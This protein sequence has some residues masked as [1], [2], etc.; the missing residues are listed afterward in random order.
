MI[1]KQVLPVIVLLLAVVTLL[2]A[3]GADPTP[4]PTSPPAATATP[5]ASSST[6]PTAAP[7]TATPTPRKTAFDELV[8]KARAATNHTIRLGLEGTDPE[9]IKAKEKAF[10][11]KFGIEIRLESEPG[12]SSREIPLKIENA[13]ASG[14]GVIDGYTGGS[15]LIIPLLQKG[16]L[17][18]PP[19]EAAYA[20]YPLAK[21]LQELAPPI[22]GGPN[23]TTMRDYCMYEGI[24]S[25]VLIYNTTNVR[26]SDVQG[27][28]LEDLTKPKWKNRVGWDNNA[29][30]LYV[31][32]FAP[33]WDVRRME[34]FANNLG[35]NGVKL[36]SGGS[37]GLVQ[38]VTQGEVDIVMASGSTAS[39]SIAAGA[40]IAI[41]YPEFVLG[42]YRVAC[43]PKPVASDPNLAGL[44]W[45]WNNF[46]GLYLEAKL[47]G[48][49]G[50]RVVDGEEGKFPLVDKARAAGITGPSLVA[51]VT[52][53][54]LKATTDTRKKAVD[55]LKA[56]IAS[57]QFI[58]Q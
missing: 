29:L 33:G 41:A 45:M 20:G 1:H 58:T 9:M 42:T 12:H 30:G 34:V 18:L 13:A 31:L 10:K 48:G 56:G 57:G 7:A 8:E 39:E 11:D 51:P 2:A 35:A 50:F 28:K 14:K 36:I 15:N 44:W 46:D 17:T 27:V 43:M 38:A 37:T 40:P 19:W 24:S 52:E 22:I 23:G 54:D 21:K 5:T 55:A 47:T 32:P 26:A 25:W 49:G 16:Y 6:T 4:T 3:C 53:A